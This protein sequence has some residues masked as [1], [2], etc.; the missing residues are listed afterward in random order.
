MTHHPTEASQR[1]AAR[2][3]GITLLLLMAVGLAGMFAR[4]GHLVVG[5]D[6]GTTA[7]NILEH[8]RR[9]RAGLVCEFVMLNCDVILAL[10]LF[11]L[12]NP[13][14]SALALL[15]SFWRIAN[16]IVLAIGVAASLVSLDFLRN[17]HSVSLLSSGQLE[18]TAMMM[19]FNFHTQVSLMGLMFFCLGA[20]VH[21]WLLL[22]SGYIPRVISGLYLFASVE[23]LLC[24]F[25]FILFSKSRAVLDPGFVVPDFLA[26]L[27]A[28]L[29]LTLKGVN[30]SSHKEWEPDSR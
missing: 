27:A 6:A 17:A 11:A 8:E 3:A 14:N 22:R 20:G 15:G 13:V 12:L 23:M 9:F 16:A 1:T 10:A 18:G 5:G 28:A 2:I 7:H 4:G 24:C 19:F 21:S 30:L 25:V 26:E 29:W